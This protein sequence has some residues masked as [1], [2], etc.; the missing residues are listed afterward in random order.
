LRSVVV[1]LLG[2]MR[3]PVEA[4]RTTLPK[5]EGSLLLELL[6][7]EEETILIEDEKL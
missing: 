2:E 1:D 6:Q 7:L 4:G 3:M 5:A